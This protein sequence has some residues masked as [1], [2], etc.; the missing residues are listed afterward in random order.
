MTRRTTTILAIGLLL[1]LVIPGVA[2]S[3]DSAV[4]MEGMAFLPGDLTIST[5]DSVTWTNKDTVLHDAVDN[6]GTWETPK[7][8]PNESASITFDKAGTYPYRCSLHGNMRATV[9]VLDPAPA[10][11]TEAASTVG[12]GGDGMAG[13]I[14]FVAGLIGLVVAARRL[15]R[16][17]VSR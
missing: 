15:R 8:N 11:D 1:P 2:R 12:A 9:R 7:L 5:G 3:A 4:T 10:T 16:A 6:G 13:W 14:P 17:A